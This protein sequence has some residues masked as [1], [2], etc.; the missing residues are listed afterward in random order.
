LPT[1]LIANE[2]G[3]NLGHAKPLAAIAGRL[4]GEDRRL[5]VAARDLLSARL[6]FPDPAVPV[7]Q[8]PIWPSHRHFGSH[9]G[10]ASYLDL[11]VTVGFADP[12]KL[13]AVVSGWMG[14]FDLVKPDVVIADHC[15]GLMVACHI[16][17][18]PVVSVGS[19]FTNPPL[20]LG[21]FPPLRADR[22]PIMPEGRVLA[23]VDEVARAYGRRAP[24][25]LAAIFGSQGRV[26]FGCREL[27]AYA[28]F[29]RETLYL[30]PEPLAGFVEPPIQPRLFVYLGVDIPRI[31]ELIQALTLLD[32]QIEAYLRPEIAVFGRLLDLAGHTVHQQ[33]PPLS[34]VLLNASH[35]LCESGATT[36]MAALAAGRPVLGLA[37]HAEAD[38]NLTMMCQLGVARRLD[39]WSDEAAIKNSLLHFIADHAIQRQARHWANILGARGGEDGAAAVARAVDACLDRP[40][41]VAAPALMPRQ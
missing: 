21:Q 26:V 25:R 1:I 20:E 14:L 8:A 19:S 16:A 9:T 4:G 12:Q 7:L 13:G 32:I 2:L 37:L 34:D 30:P 38:L 6:A 40:Q 41:P 11:L 28:A 10:Q 36:C 3:Y 27:D 35:V 15:P 17:G 39:R 29:R 18:L 31:E 22:S 24:Q 23:M 5:V 33:P